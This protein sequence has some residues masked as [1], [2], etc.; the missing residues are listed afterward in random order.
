[1]FIKKIHKKLREL[2]NE[3]SELDKYISSYGKESYINVI[4][5]G[6]EL[7]AYVNDIN[8]DIAK[9]NYEKFKEKTKL[10]RE[11]Y[12]KTLYYLI[13]RDSA[14]GKLFVDTPNI[15]NEDFIT[16]EFLVELGDYFKEKG[17][18]CE[19]FGNSNSGYLRIS[20]WQ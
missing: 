4:G 14:N 8:I 3:I 7:G 6:Y 13:N 20:G 10:K 11:D 16:Y 18:K 5:E 1:M 2:I 19:L 12:L 17:F 9:S 15:C